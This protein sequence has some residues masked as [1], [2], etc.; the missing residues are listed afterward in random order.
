M[1]IQKQS[2]INQHLQNDEPDRNRQKV[3]AQ[4]IGKM[5]SKK[6]VNEDRES[7]NRIG[8]TVFFIIENSNKIDARQQSSQVFKKRKKMQDILILCNTVFKN[9]KADFNRAQNAK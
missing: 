6:D 5:L 1:A 9:I 2:Q 8:E 7:T 3:N 4:F